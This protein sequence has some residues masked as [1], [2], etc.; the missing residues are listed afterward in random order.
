MCLAIPMRIAEFRDDGLAVAEVEGSRC[1]VDVSLVD[2]AAVCYYVIVHA[3]YAI[4][5]LDEPEARER[6]ALFA[7]LAT[8]WRPG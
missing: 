5:K 3:G 8:G 1:D 7:E 2:A 4:E 6:L